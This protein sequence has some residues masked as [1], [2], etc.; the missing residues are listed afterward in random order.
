MKLFI[1]LLAVAVAQSKVLEVP[2]NHSAYGYLEKSIAIGEKR[3]E[4]EASLEEGSRIVGGV[5]A[6]LGQYP[7]QVTIVFIKPLSIWLGI[8][9][10]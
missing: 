2:D 3:M 5:A 7:F 1:V 8:V 9:F 4:F 10:F 6:S